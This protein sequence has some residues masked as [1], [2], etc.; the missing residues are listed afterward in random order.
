MKIEFFLALC[1]VL[2]TSAFGMLS[3]ICL[4]FLK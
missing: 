4:L 2:V 1:V 3:N